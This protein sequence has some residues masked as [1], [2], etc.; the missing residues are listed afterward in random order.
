MFLRKSVASI[1]ASLVTMMHDLEEHEAAM[2]AKAD[3]HKQTAVDYNN[4]AFAANAEAANAK[5][6]RDNLAKIL[7]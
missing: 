7:N 5:V 6:V 2:S 3:A 1:T 4:K